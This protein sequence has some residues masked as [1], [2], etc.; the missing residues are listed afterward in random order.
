MNKNNFKNALFDAMSSEYDEILSES[1]NEHKF[2]SEFNKKMKKL[3]KRRQKPY[4]MLV[5][6]FSKRIACVL[7][8]V[9]IASSATVLSVD[10]A[11]NAIADLFVELHE[12]FSVIQPENKTDT[13]ETIED[14]YEITYDLSEY[15][16][17]YENYTNYKRNIIYSKDNITINFEQSTKKM[18]NENIN[19]EGA[20][21]SEIDINGNVAMYFQDNHN[22]DCLIWD[23]G[24]YIIKLHSN[25]GKNTLID[26]AKSVQKVE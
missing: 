1:E 22:Y 8:T 10:A 16:I 12:K 26:I 23:N 3:I 9:A 13:P 19:T 2:S 24:D 11:R 25:I 5:N 17:S 6:T 18:F 4:Y 20:N 21:I 7:I 15:E 14:I